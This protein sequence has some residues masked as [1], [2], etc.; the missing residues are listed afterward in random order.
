MRT[1][2]RGETLLELVVAV[3]IMGVV[4]VAFAG[5]L[6]AVTYMSDVHRK[7]SS[8]GAYVRDYAEAIENWVSAGNYPGCGA[9]NSAAYTAVSVPSFPASG[10]A[11]SAAAV[12]APNTLEVAQLTLTVNTTDNRAS[13]KLVIFVR[14]PCTA[15]PC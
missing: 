5:G 6:L 4:V 7:Q 14:K 3:A 8:A 10:Y 15:T 11:K 9:G 13:E 1:S 2:E 12:C